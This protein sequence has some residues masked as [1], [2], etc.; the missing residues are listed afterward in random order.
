MS[1]TPNNDALIHN[2]IRGRALEFCGKKIN[3]AFLN[4][5]HWGEIIE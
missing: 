1:Q 3:S 4:F 5:G 2:H